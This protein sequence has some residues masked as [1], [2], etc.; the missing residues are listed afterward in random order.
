[1]KRMKNTRISQNEET[2]SRN[3]PNE[4]KQSSALN[5]KAKNHS[6]FKHQQAKPLVLLSENTLA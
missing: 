1:M 2:I 3:A 4:I 5:N 6:S